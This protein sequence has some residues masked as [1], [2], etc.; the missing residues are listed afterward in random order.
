MV[1]GIVVY[2]RT[3]WNKKT[4]YVLSDCLTHKDR[5]YIRLLLPIVTYIVPNVTSMKNMPCCVIEF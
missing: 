4:N 2:G 1:Y 5:D 3:G